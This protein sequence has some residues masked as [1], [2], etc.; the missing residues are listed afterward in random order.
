M[1]QGRFVAAES[2]G[3]SGSTVSFNC[4]D[5]DPGGH[6]AN[7]NFTNQEWSQL[8]APG[9]TLPARWATILGS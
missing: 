2:D 5:G 3:R 1:W 7:I 8:L 9:N 4:I 6:H